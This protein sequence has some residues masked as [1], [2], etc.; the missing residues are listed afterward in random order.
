MHFN[1]QSKATTVN[2]HRTSDHWYSFQFIKYNLL[3]LL[4]RCNCAKFR[5]LELNGVAAIRLLIQPN[6]KLA[7]NTDLI[8]TEELIVS[9]IDHYLFVFAGGPRPK[10][11]FEC[12]GKVS[13]EWFVKECRQRLISTPF[14]LQI[15]RSRDS[16]VVRGHDQ[17]EPHKTGPTRLWAEEGPRAWWLRKGV[18]GKALF[19]IIGGETITPWLLYISMT[20]W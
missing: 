12:G 6:N 18:P 5:W 7:G 20:G 4:W 14:A 19:K 11:W 13:G 9:T 3:D 1:F 8:R 15:E 16:S 17:P 10:Y 2:Y